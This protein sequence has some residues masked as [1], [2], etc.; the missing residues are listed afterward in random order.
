MGMVLGLVVYEDHGVVYSYFCTRVLTLAME[1]RA[2]KYNPRIRSATAAAV[3]VFVASAVPFAASLFY[4]KANT[5]KDM[6]GATAG[7]LS[8]AVRTERLCKCSLAIVTIV[9]LVTFTR[10]AYY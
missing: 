1:L 9:F 8:D 5:L 10:S 7:L 3:A 2:A 4:A 6:G